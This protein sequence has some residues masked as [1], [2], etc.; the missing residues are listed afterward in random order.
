MDTN[1]PKNPDFV[2][3]GTAE[4]F[5]QLV[6][7]NSYK[8]VVL[9]NYWTPKA[10]PCLKLWQTL[11]PLVKEYQG[12][13][14]LVNINTDT[15]N[16]LTRDN[17]ITS[18]PTVKIYSKGKVIDTI[19]GAESEHAIRTVIDRHLPPSKSSPLAQAISA[20]QA[21]RIDDA[22]NILNDAI[23]RTP[24]DLNLCTT[25]LKIL[26]RQR[27]YTDMED[28]V[29]QR[30][31][32]LREHEEIRTILTHA[33]LMQ[34]AEQVKDIEQL[35]ADIEQEPDN[36]DYRLR[37]AALATLQ[38][39]FELALEMLL[40]ALGLDRDYQDALAR[41]AMIVIFSILGDGHALTK[42]YRDKMRAALERLP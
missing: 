10:G 38:N 19:H 18:V 32:A 7:N 16:T 30:G 31:E 24:D 33:K 28:Y 23:V 35:D 1:T 17:G 25:F 13:F 29:N 5:Q 41:K 36:I 14:L 4:N 39:E 8:G 37:R 9:A 3:D 21:G 34:L 11:E 6:M 26:F 20:Y 12:R 2:F 42:T 27:R 22:L 40:D 15:E